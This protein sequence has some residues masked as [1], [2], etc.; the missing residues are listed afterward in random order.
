MHDKLFAEQGKIDSNNLLALTSQ[1]GTD[2]DKFSDCFTKEKYLADIQTD[3]ALGEKL[4]IRGTPTLF[5]NGYKLT[6][7]APQEA[8]IKIIEGF[9]NN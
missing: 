8:L 9:L 1:I 3:Y 2:V 7:D 5:I 6:G 4:E